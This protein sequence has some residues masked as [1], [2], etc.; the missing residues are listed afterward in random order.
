MPREREGVEGKSCNNRWRRLAIAAYYLA[1]FVMITRLQVRNFKSL[2]EIDLSLGPLNVLV[3]PNMSGKSNILDVFRFLHEVFFPEAGT[4]GISYA[5]AQ[6]GGVNEVLWKGGDDKLITIA[7]EGADEADPDTRV[8]YEIELIAGG[9]DFVTTQ[10]E[11]LKLFRSGKEIDLIFFQ[12]GFLQLKNADGTDA[13]NFGSSGVSALQYAPP[14]WDGYR[15]REWVRLWRFYHLLPPLMRQSSP[16]SSGQVLMPN[17]YNL[18]AWLMWLQTK[19]P[20]AFGRINEV[21]RDLFSDITQVRTIP[22]PDGNVHL[23]ATEK[24]LKRPTKVWQTSDGFLALTALLSLVYAPAELS[25]TLFCIE[26]PENHLHP[27]LLETLVGL[28]RQVRQ[29]LLDSKISLSQIILSTQSP[30]LVDKFSLDEITWIEKKNGETR[31][32]RP[33]DKQHL[34]KL[35]E[36]KELGLGDLMFT[37]ALGEEK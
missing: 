24:G 17:G 14:N 3:G 16:M 19:S 2:R 21:L 23:A 13:G 11:S 29:E 37:G 10:N 1:G 31:L 28:L 6:R 18:S 34:K 36:N 32:H 27:R 4:Q 35:I 7:L 30:Y 15:F 5:L 12:G 22:T 33:A 9:G 25:G 26:E 8:R 20:E